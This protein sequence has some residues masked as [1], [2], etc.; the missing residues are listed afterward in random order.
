MYDGSIKYY[1]EKK[2]LSYV[3]VEIGH[4]TENEDINHEDNA[5]WKFFKNEYFDKLHQRLGIEYYYDCPKRNDKLIGLI[6]V[7]YSGVERTEG[8]CKLWNQIE[9]NDNGKKY[10]IERKLENMRMILND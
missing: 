9:N 8:I 1:P 10:H 6:H 2:N 5:L 4:S 7:R 3:E